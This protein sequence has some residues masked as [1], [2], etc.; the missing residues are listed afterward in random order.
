MSGRP[1]STCAD[2]RRLELDEAIAAGESFRAIARRFAPLSRDAIR[3]HRPHVGKAL[4]KAAEARH[5]AEAETLLEKVERLEAD[6]RR[7]GEKAEAEG[8]LRAALVAVGKL[9]DVVKLMHELTG[10]RPGPE[11]IHVEFKFPGSPEERDRRLLEI[12]AQA[13]ARQAAGPP[14][15]AEP[16]KLDA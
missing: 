8:D 4:V 6:A 1:C 3:R 7:L 11:E 15:M 13:Q 14:P 16:R 12:L 2:P 5:D 10:G 9:L